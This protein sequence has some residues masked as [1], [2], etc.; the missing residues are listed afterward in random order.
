MG[1]SRATDVPTP[2]DA[3]ILDAV[4]RLL[5]GEP[6]DL[7]TPPD[8]H[9]EHADELRI[10]LPGVLF[11]LRTPLPARKRSVSSEEAVLPA[12]Y[13]RRGTL[14][15]VGKGLLIVEGQDGP[16]RL[17]RFVGLTEPS[18]LRVYH[19]DGKDLL[20]E[21]IVGPALDSIMAACAPGGLS[22]AEALAG[23]LGG[24]GAPHC[25][26]KEAFSRLARGIAELHDRGAVHG[27][28]SPELLRVVRGRGLILTDPGGPGMPLP[29]SRAY[30]FAAPELLAEPGRS[31]HPASDWFSFGAILFAVLTGH[32]PVAGSPESATLAEG[33]LRAGMPERL[34]KAVQ[35]LLS[36]D[37]KDR[38]DGE[39][40]ASDGRSERP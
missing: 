11:I 17:V 13:R 3:I 12:G 15:R 38:P 31:P 19:L 9:P 25:R 33:V 40:L 6:I 21:R 14:G 30:P 18:L 23:A 29:E 39:V 24:T 32:P 28:L 10:R 2:V 36:P 1:S 27:R 20:V 4:E 37:P 7:A 5:G 22:V 16:G 35:R 34:A 8:E 26:I